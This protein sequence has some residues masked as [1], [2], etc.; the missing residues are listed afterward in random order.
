[1]VKDKPII[2]IKDKLFN[3]LSKLGIPILIGLI[4]LLLNKIRLLLYPKILIISE[5]NLKDRLV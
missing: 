1:M 5:L 4:D 2:N 3:E